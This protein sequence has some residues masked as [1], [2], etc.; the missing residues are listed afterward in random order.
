MNIDNRSLFH[1]DNLGFLR[2][3]NSETIDLIATDP[4]FNKGRDFH[5]TPDSLAAGSSFQ[6]RWSWDKDVHPAWVDK[7]K[8]DFPQI[9]DVVESARSTHSDGM[10]AFMCFMA[11]RL[12]EMR[13]VLKP[14]GS[15]Y[16]HCDPTAS[17]YLRSIMN[18]IFGAQN[19]RNEIVW[20]RTSAHSRVKRWGPI[21]DTI[22]F[23]SK[24][25]EYTWNRV[26][27]ARPVAKS[28]RGYSLPDLTGAG[29][30]GKHVESG[31][32]WR[33]FDVTAKGRH[34]AVPQ[35]VLQREYPNKNLAALSV[36]QKLDL[37]DKAGR[38]HFPSSGK[39]PR[40]KLYDSE[41]SGIPLQSICDD[42]PV[43][44]SASKEQT[45]YPTQ[46]PI[47]LYERII[48]ASSNPGDFVLDPFCGCATT[49]VAAERLGRQ[50]AGIDIWDKARELVEDRLKRDADLRKSD[51]TAKD[52][53]PNGK[54]G[55]FTEPPKRTDDGL[56][57]APTLKT[58]VKYAQREPDG[59]KQSRA[60]MLAELMEKYGSRCQ[61]CNRFFDDPRYLQ[62][63]HNTPRADGGVNHISNRILLCGPCNQLKSNLFTLSGL[64]QENEK[65]GYMK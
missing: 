29:V 9:G 51:G 36:L 1:G 47:A 58:K 31:Q 48:R 3:I 65:R 64:R 19:F 21:H 17:N 4:P 28:E 63:D 8:D 45:G 52:M 13:R 12:L 61:G 50:W 41:K 2:A 62:L 11:V 25:K 54:I 10:G 49:L 35:A 44:S 34:W 59:P 22:L 42:I 55:C 26:E 39:L 33:G 40:Y 20:K 7:L 24:G 43:V 56:E 53:F 14:A 15:I 46:K 30:S 5:A 60:E 27:I 18:A 6:D 32:V 57:A 37:L 38:V 23:Y 16:L